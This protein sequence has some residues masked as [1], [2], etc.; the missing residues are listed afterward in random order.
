MQRFML[1]VSQEV[2]QEI[3]R[4]L[5]IGDQLLIIERLEKKGLKVS[6]S[7]LNQFLK[8][9]KPMKTI[10]EPVVAEARLMFIERQAANEEALQSLKAIAA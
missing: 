2:R 6:P 7:S 4:R 1:N 10:G 8:G 9:R 3:H 5:Q